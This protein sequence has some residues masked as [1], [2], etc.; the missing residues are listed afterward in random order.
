MEGEAD[1]HRELDRSF[2]EHWERPRLA[3]AHRAHLRV[4]LGAERVGARAEQLGPRGELAVDLQPDH[5][6]P[7]G[8][9]HS[10]GS[11]VKPASASRVRAVLNMT[12][13]P[14]TGASTCT[15]I[16]SPCAS[17]PTGTEMAGAP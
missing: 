2:V 4:G 3:E 15:P 14:S 12:A 6:F 5:R 1:A 17:S 7:C 11:W 16:G 10:G 9:R 13:S 8:V